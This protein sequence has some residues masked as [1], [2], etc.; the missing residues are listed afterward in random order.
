MDMR[1]FFLEEIKKFKTI[2]EQIEILKSRDLII[3]DEK[4]AKDYLLANNYYNLINGYSK[5]FFV[6]NNNTDEEKHYKQGT[7]FD[8]ICSVYFFDK[9]IKEDFFNYSIDVEHHLKSLFA[10][11]FSKIYKDRRYP[12]LD[13]DCYDSNKTTDV[14]YSIS[15]MSSIIKNKTKYHNDN[16][17]IYHYV[18]KYGE[19]PIW[20]MID[21]LDFGLLESLMFNSITTIQNNVAKDC[22]SFIKSNNSEFDNIFPPKAMLSFIKNIRETRNIC[23]HNNRLIGFKCHG[24]IIYFH[25]IFDQY[26][27]F[28]KNGSRRNF[29]TTMLSM[30]CF[31][32]SIEYSQLHNS[33]RKRFNRLRN[34]VNP[35]TVSQIEKDLGFPPDWSTN[36]KILE[37]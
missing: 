8:E 13:I 30:Q 2:D 19:V 5:H 34:K 12:Y 35:T 9:Q 21:Y 24:D 26:G 6:E 11:N 16:N 36:T 10:Y 27:D 15:K 20:V 22:I 23:A 28:P 1:S 33:I 29:Y 17:S 32:S 4:R 7:T 37:Q 14:I 25:P 18:K 31:L 3:V